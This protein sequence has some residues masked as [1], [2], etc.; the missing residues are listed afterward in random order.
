MFVYV[1]PMMTL[2]NL[3]LPLNQRIALMVVF[4]FGSIVVLAACMRLYYTHQTVYETYDVT[5][6][7]YNLW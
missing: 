6:D 7:G 5:W 3:K 1:L 4:G 2:A